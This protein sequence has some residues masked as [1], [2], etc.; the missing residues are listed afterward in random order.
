MFWKEAPGFAFREPP[1]PI[2]RP[3]R[4]SL[5]VDDAKLMDE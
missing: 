4:R 5:M 3:A 2:D 1:A